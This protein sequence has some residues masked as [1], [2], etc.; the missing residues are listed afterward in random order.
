MFI[1]VPHY[2][3]GYF[4]KIDPYFFQNRKQEKDGSSFDNFTIRE[5]NWNSIVI[6]KNNLY[7]VGRDNKPNE[8][9][10]DKL[11]FEKDFID[12]SGLTSFEIWRGK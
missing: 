12:Y 2:Y 7:I 3:I 6:E 9:V 4:N 10:K 11:I 8:N 5:I 1:G